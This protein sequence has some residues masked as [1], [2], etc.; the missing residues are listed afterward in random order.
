MGNFRDAVA[1][2]HFMFRVFVEGV[3]LM[4]E[5]SSRNATLRNL[6]ALKKFDLTRWGGNSKRHSEFSPE[7]AFF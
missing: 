6:G 2:D 5:F 3:R 4:L 7:K 1:Q